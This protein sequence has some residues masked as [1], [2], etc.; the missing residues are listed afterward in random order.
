MFQRLAPSLVMIVLAAA[1][2]VAPARADIYTWVDAK[3]VTNVSNLAPP[4]GVSVKNIA[5]SPPKDPAR[6]A[7][8][9]EAAQHEA[10]MQA[11][12]ERLAQMQFALEQSGR[13][14]YP[15]MA[16]AP[17]PTVVVVQPPPMPYANFAPPPAYDAGPG[18]SPINGCDYSFNCG[19]WWG[20]G[21]YSTTV[22]TTRG[23][24]F[25]RRFAPVYSA[26]RQV[27]PPLIPP[28]QPPPR[29]NVSYHRH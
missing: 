11:L 20:P 16:Y 6:E 12:N 3:G 4:E 10:E 14:A 18:V 27:V 7:A 24:N 21:F 28:A 22:V 8:V 29:M 23:K 25:H 17:P 26:P 13:A 9:R 1:V 5:P 2:S 15:P 19:F